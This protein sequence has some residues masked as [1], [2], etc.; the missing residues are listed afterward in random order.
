VSELKILERRQSSQKF[1]VYPVTGDSFSS[2]GGFIDQLAIAQPRELSRGP[3]IAFSAHLGIYS[4]K[5]KSGVFTASPASNF[6]SACIS[7]LIQVELLLRLYADSN[8]GR[9]LVKILQIA[10]CLSIC[11]NRHNCI[12]REKFQV[13]PMR[14]DF[15]TYTESKDSTRRCFDVP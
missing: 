5:L 14:G 7:Q 6:E 10:T 15:Y 1:G 12:Q 9:L 3:K 11:I 4:N 2:K 13:H 8:L